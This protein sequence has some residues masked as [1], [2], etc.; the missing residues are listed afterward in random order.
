MGGQHHVLEPDQRRVDMRL[1]LEHIEP[2]PRDPPF[3][4]GLDEGGLVHHGPPRGVDEIG[5]LLHRPERLG[6]DQVPGL[7]EQ[8]RVERD[9]VRL[10]EKRREVDA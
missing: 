6:I 8:G 9:E 10:P 1:V 7:G 4:Q 5:G 3:R 2:S